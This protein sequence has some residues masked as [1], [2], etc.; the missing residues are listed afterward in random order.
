[1][2]R[3]HG[4]RACSRS[5][6]FGAASS[7]FGVASSTS[8]CRRSTSTGGFSTRPIGVVHRVAYR[9]GV[10]F[11]LPLGPIG[12]IDTQVG[13]IPW[14]RARCARGGAD[15]TDEAAGAARCR[16]AA[17]G[18]LAE[19]PREWRLSR[20][21]GQPRGQVSDGPV[22]ATGL[23]PAMARRRTG[24]GPPTALRQR[25]PAQPAGRS[26]LAGGGTARSQSG[27][28]P[29]VAR[30]SPASSATRGSSGSARYASR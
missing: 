11:C 14:V 27:R 30:S 2:L 19:R 8:G 9:T 21:R 23:S 5:S 10:R 22:P 7:T 28:A 4:F 18:L 17:G 24:D 1:M 6:T 26:S 29:R 3:M 25:E 13:A 15:V 16:W 12:S 20:F